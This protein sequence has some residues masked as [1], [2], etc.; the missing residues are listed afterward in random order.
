M[1]KLIDEYEKELKRLQKQLKTLQEKNSKMN[2]DAYERYNNGKR[3][4]SVESQIEDVYYSINQ[5][6]KYLRR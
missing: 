4:A 1:K 2:L 5:M 3:I 6:K